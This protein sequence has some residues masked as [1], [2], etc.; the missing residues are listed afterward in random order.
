MT[1]DFA[2]PRL[3]LIYFISIPLALFL[4]YLMATPLNLGSLGVVS[5]CLLIL[6]FPVFMR[7]HH[8]MLLCAWHASL[9]L[10][11]LPG[12][13]PLWVVLAIGNIAF[14]V[15]NRAMKKEVRYLHVP[16]L[17]LPVLFLAA[18]VGVT[19]LLTGGIGARVLGSDMYGGS[20]YFATFAAIIGYFGLVTQPIVRGRGPLLSS[21]FFL[22]G[23]TAVASDVVYAAG[24]RF[25]F[26]FAFFPTQ[27]AYLQAITQD[28][29]V[30]STGLTW[31]ALSVFYFTLLRF[32]I[33]GIMDFRRPWRFLLFAGALV[34]GFYGGYRS[35]VLLMAFVFM[36]QFFF[37]GLHRTVILPILIVATL[38]IGPIFIANLDRMPLTVQRSFS[39]LPVRVD[40]QA[41]ADAAATVDWRVTMWRI[42]LPEV[43]KYLLLGRGYSFSGSEFYLTQE[44]VKNGIYFGY[45][46][47]LVTGDYHNG[48]LTLIIPF[49]IWGMIGFCWLGAAGTLALWRNWRYGDPSLKQVNTFLLSYFSSR[50]LFYFTFYGKFDQDLFVFMGALGLSVALNNGVRSA[51]DP[52]SEAPPTEDK[53]EPPAAVV[54][55]QR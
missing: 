17:T 29:F 36:V 42:M 16:M 24:P 30:R 5:F 23:V 47:A 51:K 14:A 2:L 13:P 20:R 43:P 7:Q 12:Q 32:G 33:R 15:V 48:L 37:E 40:P 28:A 35:S 49:G 45:E 55:A 41:K 53:A 21:L 34:A 39:F 27:M 44:A 52:W 1:R 10:Y 54:E 8:A 50:F 25:Y 18:A 19:A 38:I 11:F 4:G 6:A 31:A 26:L 46:E 9:I 22:G 3:V